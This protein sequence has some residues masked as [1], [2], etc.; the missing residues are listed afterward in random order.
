VAT[1]QKPIMSVAVDSDGDVVAAQSSNGVMISQLHAQPVIEE[2]PSLDNLGRVALSDSG[3]TLIVT[4]ADLEG[5][6]VNV[7]D[8]PTD[9]VRHTGRTL[10]TYVG[11]AVTTDDEVIVLDSAGGSWERHRLSDWSVMTSGAAGFKNT[12]RDAQL[13]A[14]GGSFIYADDSADALVWPTDRPTDPEAAPSSLRAPIGNPQAVALSPDGTTGAVADTGV[15]YVGP[16]A[17]ADESRATATALVGDGSIDA[18]S[19]RFLGADQLVASSGARLVQWDLTAID[20]LARTAAVPLDAGCH[21]CGPPTVRVAPDG[22]AAFVA[23][24]SGWSGE[25]IDLPQLTMRGERFHFGDALYEGSSWTRRGDHLVILVSGALPSRPPPQ[26]ATL[27]H[28]DRK[29]LATGTGPGDSDVVAVMNDGQVL[30]IDATTGSSTELASPL[31]TGLQSASTNVPLASVGAT[32]LAAFAQASTVT[33]VDPNTRT[34]RTRDMADT[35]TAVTVAGTRVL[36]RTTDNR[37]EVW[38]SSLTTRVRAIPVEASDLWAPVADA[39]GDVIAQ[40]R[41]DS[42][43]RL[44]DV[45]TGT[46]LVTFRATSSSGLRAGTGFSPDGTTII[47]ATEA[48][49]YGVTGDGILVSR[50]IQPDALIRTACATAGRE[51]TAGEWTQ[52]VDAPAPESLACPP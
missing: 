28:V 25:F 3:R 19:V 7:V 16:V 27:V 33:A 51:L 21:A 36:V 1:L 35:V 43:V 31:P 49:G 4:L 38:D 9:T 50:S 37:M 5:G 11:L 34:S 39:V 48:G 47:T 10:G 46:E 8:V 45:D 52:A 15:V 29:V 12:I 13:A 26:P 6:W 24:G 42:T 2:D 17:A 23:D 32:G 20:R 44:I 22:S 18:G 14:G 41:A 30:S 40:S